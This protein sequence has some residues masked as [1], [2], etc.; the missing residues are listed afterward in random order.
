MSVQK[1]CH[2]QRLTVQWNFSQPSALSKSIVPSLF[3]HQVANTMSTQSSTSALT[4]SQLTEVLGAVKDCMWEEMQSFKRELLQEKSDADYRLPKKPRL[5][6]GPSF[7]KKSH[8]K[9]FQFNAS[10][11]PQQAPQVSPVVKAKSPLEEGNNFIR[12]RHVN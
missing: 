3:Q 1:Y 6:K 8:E 7:K 5:E 12:N 11:A 4:P 2:S 9:Q 10:V